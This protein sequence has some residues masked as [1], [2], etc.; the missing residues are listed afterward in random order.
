M[1]RKTASNFSRFE[2]PADGLGGIPSGHATA[3]IPRRQARRSLPRYRAS[4]RSPARVS[5]SL[6]QRLRR[7]AKSGLPWHVI[8]DLPDLVPVARRELEVIET[9][10]AALLD[11]SLEGIETET[12]NRPIK[13]GKHSKKV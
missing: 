12:E 10:L 8:D 9:Y 11:D 4:P 5:Q 2:R 6:P 3:Q 1:K 13:V 7:A